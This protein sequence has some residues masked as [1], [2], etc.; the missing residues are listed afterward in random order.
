MAVAGERA[1]GG[2]GLEAG[3][4]PGFDGPALAIVAE[5]FEIVPPAGVFTVLV[6]VEGGKAGV[7]VVGGFAVVDAAAA[8]VS[9]N[10]P[11]ALIVDV[12]FFVAH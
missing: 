12:D 7:G 8:L 3:V 5:A 4:D 10:L 9:N 2:V 6:E 11:Y 1:G